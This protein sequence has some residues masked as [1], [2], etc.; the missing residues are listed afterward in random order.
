MI[1]LMIAILVVG[2]VLI[3]APQFFK[4]RFSQRIFIFS[5]AVRFALMIL[6]VEGFFN[7]PSSD[8]L[9]F[10]TDAARIALGLQ[11]L[12]VTIASSDNFNAFHAALFYLFGASFYLVD[13]VGLLGFAA[14]VIALGRLIRLLKLTEFEPWI[15][16]PF[17]FLPGSLIYLDYNTRE[18]FQVLFLILMFQGIIQYRITGRIVSLVWATLYG[19][20]FAITHNRYIVV[21]PA[22]IAVGI[23][24]P[25]LG[26]RG[27]TT[28][29]R[30]L[31]FPVALILLLIVNGISNSQGFLTT[32]QDTGLVNYVSDSIN[33]GT[34]LLA[35]TQFPFV[36]TATDPVSFLLALPIMAVQFLFAPIVPFMVT[37]PVDVFPA[38]DTL[39]RIIY[40]FGTIRLIRN[41]AAPPLLRDTAFFLLVSYLVFCGISLLGT[42]NVGTQE[43]HQ[44]KI[45]WA[46]MVAGAPVIAAMFSARARASW[47]F[48]MRRPSRLGRAFQT[49][50]SRRG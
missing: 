31:V 29:R 42:I 13:A 41:S 37:A 46:L 5:I 28:F 27:S 18:V 47:R 14:S 7:P 38:I 33:V 19:Y 22:F 40:L 4:S 35:R 12:I 45:E 44:M 36:L 6:S 39:V 32:V 49:V 3:T 30:I 10:E 20:L 50:P 23:F 16:I 43:R 34:A 26:A 15:L 1:G 25:N 11:P 2:V 21:V 9:Q 24:L 8:F 48:A 17:C